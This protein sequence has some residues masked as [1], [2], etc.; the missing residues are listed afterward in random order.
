MPIL[1]VQGTRDLLCPLDLLE[2][3]R[4]GITAPNFLHIVDEGDHSLRV[5]KRRLQ[6]TGE[7]QD[8]VDA[9]VLAA[10]GAFVSR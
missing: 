8:D 3:V 10:I 5:A 1:F 7:T 6:A 9:R 2:E 4:A